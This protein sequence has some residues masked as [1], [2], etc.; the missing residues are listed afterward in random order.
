MS[1]NLLKN[2]LNSHRNRKRQS[3]RV[4][5]RFEPALQRLQDR[6]VP[7]VVAS[8]AAD[9]GQLSI[10]GDSKGNVISISRQDDGSILIN[11]GE[12]AISGGIP[13]INNTTTIVAFG[14]GGDGQITLNEF[15]GALP[16]AIF[17]GGSSNDLLNGGS[18]QDFL[19]GNSGND[20][21]RGRGNEDDIFGG[22][23]NDTFLGDRGNDNLHGQAG[24]DL[25]IVNNGDGS[26]F[27]E[28]GE[29]FDTV[30]VNGSNTDRDVIF[31]EHNGNRVR[32]ERTNIDVFVLDIGTT[33]TLDIN[34]FGVKDYVRGSVGLAELISLEIDGGNGSDV[35]LGGD[36]NDVLS[37]GN[38]N[39][40]LLA[41]DGNDTMN[42]G[43]ETV[44]LDCGAGEDSA[45]NGEPLI[46]V[47]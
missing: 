33:E 45:I 1:R 9:I 15:K 18:G 37:G 27:L 8:F 47:P 46:N 43:A 2:L 36:D 13:T 14:L 3:L 34:V 23:G 40:I 26:D 21:I 35:L 17:L 6:V 28:A 12:I 42:G 5:R 30:Q 41:G 44:F 10:T 38:G 24:S 4:T 19:S 20:T 22:S 25:L 39:D 11:N 16:R 7:A 32:V 29:G 31:V